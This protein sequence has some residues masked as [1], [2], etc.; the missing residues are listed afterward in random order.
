MFCQETSIQWRAEHFLRK[1]GTA[2]CISIGVLS[3]CHREPKTHQVFRDSSGMS[4]DRRASQSEDRF[5][6]IIL[7]LT[8]LVYLPTLEVF[9]LLQN[10]DTQQLIGHTALNFC[11]ANQLPLC[12]AQIQILAI[13]PMT[14]NPNK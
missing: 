14:L 6:L 4:S 12:H 2:P 8:P 5:P 1:N 7:P 11:G 10:S 13:K 9:T 3:C